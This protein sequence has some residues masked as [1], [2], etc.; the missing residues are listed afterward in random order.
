MQQN[1]TMGRATTI[2][3]IPHN[4]YELDSLLMGKSRMIIQMNDQLFYSFHFQINAPRWRSDV[5]LKT[6]E[7]REGIV[8]VGAS[9]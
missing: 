2:S 7:Q 9:I 5:V 8:I 6:I 1:R 4:F 3:P